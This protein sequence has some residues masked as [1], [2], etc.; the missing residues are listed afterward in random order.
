MKTFDS[1]AWVEFFR[2]SRTGESVKRIVEGGEVLFTPSVCLAEIKV[3]YLS[4][5]RD[6][7]DRLS[8][9]K[10]RTSIVEVDADVAEEAADL[11]V[12]YS[13][14][15]IDALILACARKAGGELV[16]GDK[17]LQGIPGVLMVAP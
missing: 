2:G 1:W 3:K 17:H 12:R 9:M 10:A 14:H 16:T 5:G 6:P 13:L 4:E 8:F 7:R 11:K 15:M